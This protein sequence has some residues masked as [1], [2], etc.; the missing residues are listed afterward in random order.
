MTTE[1]KTIAA[2]TATITDQNP[3]ANQ[4]EAT[5]DDEAILEL[6]KRR[7]AIKRN[8]F[9]QLFDYALIL[10]CLALLTVIWDDYERFLVALFFSFVWGARLLYRI[11][12][13]ARPSFREGIGAYL[14]KR[15]D[16][17]LES[18]FNRLKKDYLNSN[19]G[20]N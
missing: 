12:K 5:M 20:H 3:A 17:K 4:I 19:I 2:T 7:I 15:N 16:Y 6:A 18:E 14:K 11:L 8:L 13:F 1:H 10:I 9:Y